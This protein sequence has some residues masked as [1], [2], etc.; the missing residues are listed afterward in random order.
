MTD[1]VIRPKIGLVPGAKPGSSE[2]VPL[3][4]TSWWFRLLAQPPYPDDG[5]TFLV[6][7]RGPHRLAIASQSRAGL[8]VSHRH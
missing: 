1:A 3:V 6:A 8:H 4:N 7:F 5:K 2:P